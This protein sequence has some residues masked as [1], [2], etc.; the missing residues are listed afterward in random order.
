MTNFNQ[1]EKSNK[2]IATKKSKIPSLFSRFK[3]L[4][5]VGPYLLLLG[6]ILEALTIVMRRW[7]SI[8][9]SLS[10]EMQ[11]IFS[12]VCIIVC[13]MGIIWFNRWLNLIKV[14]FSGT[15]STLVTHGP[16]NYVRHPL[17][18]NLLF[19]VP[20]IL[21]ACFS[22]LL[23]L[24]TWIVIFVLSHF[25]IIMEEQVLI[26]IFGEDYTN[27]QRFVPALIPYKGAAGRRYRKYC[28][29]SAPKNK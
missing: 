3:N 2:T 17:Y 7:V 6:I 28:D 12:I 14:N 19:T 1:F 26:R 23:F 20:P 16:F 24:F 9:M 11:V 10:F 5:G 25:I 15:E 4:M 27:Y 29:V 13:L 21:I 18:A 8:P 22:D